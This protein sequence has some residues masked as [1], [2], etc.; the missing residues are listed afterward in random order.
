MCAC[1]CSMS[2]QRTK[3]SRY[4]SCFIA[5]LKLLVCNDYLLWTDIK[6]FKGLRS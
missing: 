5:Y 6:C 1:V 2:R 4:L 3:C